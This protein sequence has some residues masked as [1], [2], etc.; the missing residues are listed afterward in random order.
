VQV[1]LSLV[2]LVGAGLF[3]RTFTSLANLPLGFDPRPVLVATVAV[4]GEQLP[5]AERPQFFAR[6]RDAA[7]SVPGVSHVALSELTPLGGS[8]WNNYVEVLGGPV[9][10]GDDRLSYF[11]RVS[12]GWFQTYGTRLLAG[13]D[14]T[15][16]DTIGTPPV[17]IVNEAFARH[18]NRGRNPIGLHVRQPQNVVREVV[19]M[20]ADSAYESLRN[21]APPTLYL[22]YGQEAH[23]QADTAVSVRAAT[24][25]P[26]LLARPL[27][28]AL[29]RVHPDLT[30]STRPLS[31]QVDALMTQE[32]LVAAL[33]AVF[34]VLALFLAGLG[35]YGVTWYAVSRRRTEIG[36][37]LALG[38][39]PRVV[40]ALVLR[41]AVLF[42]GLG[43]VAGAA[44]SLWASRFV[45]PL[46]FGLSAR[47]PLTLLVAM[48]VLT[49]IGALAAWLP[50]R[51]ASRIDP[52]RVLREG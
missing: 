31:D 23:L 20:V 51:H 21:P 16:D 4:P 11:N 9:M 36:I 52:V 34:G 27:A 41:R 24:G 14:F 25:S 45:T 19:G 39:E 44:V 40:L 10:T 13:R 50:A 17:A 43:I 5:S 35:L 47:D 42:I 30:V 15:A 8:S 2:L 38:A 1:A 33:A 22:A 7:A 28:A 18:F 37:R 26:A 12:V 48:V 3:V 46:L 32:R 6:L 49:T 29:S